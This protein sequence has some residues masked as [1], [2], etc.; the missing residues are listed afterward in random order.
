M[1]AAV[2]NR[3]GWTLDESSPS[4]ITRRWTFGC[5]DA[6]VVVCGDQLIGYF[7]YV[8]RQENFRAPDAAAEYAERVLAAMRETVLMEAVR[9]IVDRLRATPLA[10]IH[11]RWHDGDCDHCD[12]CAASPDLCDRGHSERENPPCTCGLAIV[13]ELIAL[14]SGGGR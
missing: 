9:G 11:E 6:R 8:S 3:P 14:V 5:D 13:D 12:H 4:P 10:N 1:T 2:L 7:A